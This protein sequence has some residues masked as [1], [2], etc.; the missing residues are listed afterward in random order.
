MQAGSSSAD[1]EGDEEEDEGEEDED[2]DQEEQPPS[3]KAKVTAPGR[4]FARNVACTM[5]HSITTAGTHHGQSNA[6]FIRNPWW[7][8]CRAVCRVNTRQLA[9]YLSGGFCDQAG[10][11][12]A[13][14][15]LAKQQQQQQH[16]FIAGV[17]AAYTQQH[18]SWCKCCAG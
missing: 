18:P 2:D 13:G 15:S 7:T 1:D 3:K 11:I 14:L 16:N 5:R 4:L 17:Q 9:M 6:T 8:H 12:S 10:N